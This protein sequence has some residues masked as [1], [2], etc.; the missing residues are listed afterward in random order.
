MIKEIID[1]IIRKD[2]LEITEKVWGQELLVVNNDKYC[3]KF[4]VL[5]ANSQS[6][7]H[8]HPKKMETF[9]AIKGVAQLEIEEKS[10]LLTPFA[11]PKTI[12]P[13]QKHSFRGITDCVILEVST[14]H[15][16]ED[17]VRLIASRRL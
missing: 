14:P 17:V 4:L 8:Y 1:T 6:S 10:C 9:Y 16:D 3:G 7:L 11:R 5:R 13:G 2:N 15:S 12:M